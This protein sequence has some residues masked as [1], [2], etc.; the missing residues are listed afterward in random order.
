MECAFLQLLETV[1]HDSCLTLH[2]ADLVVCPLQLTLVATRLPFK[3]HAYLRGYLAVDQLCQ[4]GMQVCRAADSGGRALLL[5]YDLRAAW[6][7]P[8]VVEL[9]L[10]G[11][12][13][14]LD[15][16]LERVAVQA[17]VRLLGLYLV[18][19]IGELLGD[20]VEAP[21]KILSE[22]L[23]SRGHSQPDLAV[24]LVVQPLLFSS[25]QCV[26]VLLLVPLQVITKI[27]GPELD[28]ASVEVRIQPDCEVR[29]DFV[30]LGVDCLHP[31]GDLDAEAV[32]RVKLSD[33]IGQARIQGALYFIDAESRGRDLLVHGLDHFRECLLLAHALLAEVGPQ[34]HLLDI[35]LVYLVLK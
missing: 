11:Q 4:F 22:L 10:E 7:L 9:L 29:S 20:V 16:I 5:H 6:L 24:H 30:E 17:E 23:A 31:L 28:G 27:G 12:D 15:S 8:Q 19:V 1:L 35:E 18:D 32:G 26:N 14:L 3:E 34:P 2:L 25:Q 13:G 33:S 21:L